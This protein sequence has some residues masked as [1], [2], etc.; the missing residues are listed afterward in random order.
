MTN[1]YM[2]PGE[3]RCSSQRCDRRAT[4]VRARAPYEDGRPVQDYSATWVYSSALCGGFVRLGFW[5][6]PVKSTER[7]AKEWIGGRL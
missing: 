1:T 3:P 4:C 5:K 7:E 2:P 6:R